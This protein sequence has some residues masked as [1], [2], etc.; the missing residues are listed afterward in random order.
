M[1]TSSIH[2]ACSGLLVALLATSAWAQQPAAA[3]PQPVE[4]AAPPAAPP[5]A[6]P[7]A[8]PLAPPVAAPA[9]AA[10]PPLA[11]PV[12][13]APSV[14]W[15]RVL[16]VTPVAQPGAPAL[17]NCG[18]A[19]EVPAPTSGAGAVAGALLGAAVGSQLGGG[20]GQA[21]GAAA[22][23][24]GGAVLGDRAEQ[25]GRT[26]TV[27]PCTRAAPSVAYQVIYEYGGQSYSA[28]LP[29]HP[30]ALLQVQVAP[31][32]PTAGASLNGVGA[33]PAPVSVIVSPAVWAAA[34][35][36]LAIGYYR[37]AWRGGFHGG[38]R[39]HRHWRY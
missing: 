5:L 32:V 18:L 31:V 7:A 6:S 1:K 30:G 21:L 9:T 36:A 38:W 28:L 27:Q 12:P 23:F 11:P 34:P 10:A 19:S 33:V 37:P 2:A 22:G 20:S 26:Q 24:V 4:P 39:G 13:V 15:A 8:A 25:G 3:V 29:F 14:A 16:S 17:V 35:A